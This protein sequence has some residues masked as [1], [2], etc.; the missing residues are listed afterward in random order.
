MQE[1]IDKHSTNT[2][3]ISTTHAHTPKTTSPS[4]SLSPFNKNIVDFMLLIVNVSV[5][6]CRGLVSANVCPLIFKWSA[7]KVEL[8]TVQ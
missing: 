5:N 4:L 1:N 3:T 7:M 2:I 8:V 6:E